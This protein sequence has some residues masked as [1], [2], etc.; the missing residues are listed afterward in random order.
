M[1]LLCL[2]P[3]TLRRTKVVKRILFRRTRLWSESTPAQSLYLYDLSRSPTMMGTSSLSVAG[4]SSNPAPSITVLINNLSLNGLEWL[5]T[6]PLPPPPS[7]YLSPLPSLSPLLPP[8]PPTT[9]VSSSSR[10]SLGSSF[11]TCRRGLFFILFSHFHWAILL[12]IFEKRSFG[13]LSHGSTPIGEKWKREKIF[14]LEGTK[15]SQDR[16]SGRETS[17]YRKGS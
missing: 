2:P 17:L 6:P 1:F 13:G 9:L 11:C 12:K 3:S 4:I 14:H 15:E 8:C 16:P 5:R 10:S 7:L